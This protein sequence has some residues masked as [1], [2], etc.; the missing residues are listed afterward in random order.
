MEHKTVNLSNLSTGEQSLKRSVLVIL[1]T[2]LII[3][4]FG[5]FQTIPSGNMI[6]EETQ[7]SLPV[8]EDMKG[9]EKSIRYH[10]DHLVPT[11][12]LSIPE[13]EADRIWA[14]KNFFRFS[15]GR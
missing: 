15:R 4:S 2:L 8:V 7:A 14:S 11:R 6:I 3:S 12:D 13:I 1:I 5:A 10:Y 9:E